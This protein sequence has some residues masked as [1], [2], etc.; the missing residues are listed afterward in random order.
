MAGIVTSKR[1]TLAAIGLSAALCA[2]APSSSGKKAQEEPDPLLVQ[3]LNAPLMIDPDLA[4]LNE[5]NAALT[6]GFNQS[7]PPIDRSADTIALA[8]DTARQFLLEGGD[9]PNLPAAK[10]DASIPD[11][12]NALTSQQRAEILGLADKCAGEFAYSTVWA[13]RLPEFAAIYPRGAVVEAAGHDAARCGM[14]SLTYLSPVPANEIAQFHYTL[15]KRAKLSPRVA[16]NGEFA[17]H[18]EGAAGRLAL[19]IR[20]R[21]GGLTAIDMV[22]IEPR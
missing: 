7:I 21:E 10:A 12:S 11:L 22:V 20:E 8:K 19:H 1:S 18:G 4:S 5:A 15:A 16:D 14:R 6:V 2:C 3:A 13:A 17:I 9:I